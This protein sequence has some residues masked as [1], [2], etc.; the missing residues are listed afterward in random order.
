MEET[1]SSF[2]SERESLQESAEYS[3]EKTTH[4][5]AFLPKF[6]ERRRHPFRGSI[7]L[8]LVFTGRNRDPRTGLVHPFSEKGEYPC[9]GGIRI[10]KD[11]LPESLHESAE[12]SE[13]K[14]THSYAFLPKFNEIL[15]ESAEYS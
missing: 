8:P 10:N 14:T 13:E 15:Q 1:S 6:D 7:K 11:G 2:T 12:Y 9:S 4:S 5:Y 3:E